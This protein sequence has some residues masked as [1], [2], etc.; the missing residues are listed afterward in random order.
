MVDATEIRSLDSFRT[1][2]DNLNVADTDKISPWSKPKLYDLTQSVGG[3]IERLVDWIVSSSPRPSR[4]LALAAVIAFLGALIGR[5]F[6]SP[7]DLRTNFYIVALAPSGFGKDHAR[8][9][10]KKLIML[11]E[12]EVF[13]GPGRFMS[14]TA[15]R[16]AMMAKPSLFCMIDEFGGMMRQITDRKAGL[17]NQ[18]IKNDL[19]EL[20]SSAATYFEGAE[21]AGSKA[22]RIYNPNLCI[23]GTSTPDDFWPS[24]SSL[25]TSDG[26][27][28]RYILF[29][30]A[31][32]KPSRVKPERD[33]SDVPADLIAACQALVMANRGQG[34]FRSVLDSGEQP[35]VPTRVPFSEEAKELLAE[36]NDYI[37]GQEECADPRALPFLNRTAEHAIKLALLSAV[38]NDVKNPIVSF[39][40]MVWAA[41]LAWHSTATMIEQARDRIAD[42]AREA[43][44]NRILDHIKKAG[45]E[46]IT[47]G[48]V[49]D[50]CRSIEKRKREEIIQDLTLSGRV[51]QQITPTTGRPM[52]RLYYVP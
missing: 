24:L 36:L 30:V 11:A 2:R 7:T 6:A 35:V 27:L 13:S 18:L 33:V 32:P 46:G 45:D 37:E 51:R 12:L 17:H 5:R 49:A 22:K 44:M 1:E 29:D 10:L 28:P 8:A 52:N 9:Q 50:R 16:N 14:A 25:N 38:A 23:C 4:E 19:L 26:L 21:Y 39:E 34:K 20:F 48:T 42:N 31:G 43:D 41:D 40:D 15:L 3:L 47:P